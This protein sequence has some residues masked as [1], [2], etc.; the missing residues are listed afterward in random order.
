MHIRGFSKCKYQTLLFVCRFM[1]VVFKNGLF[2]I[3]MLMLSGPALGQVDSV[4]VNGD[5][6]PEVYK[7]NYRVEVP[8]TV[9]GI[10]VNL[11]NFYGMSK[12]PNSTEE[13]IQSLNK[14]NI[15]FFD[16][17]TVHVYSKSIDQASYIPFY[18]AIPLPL[19]C[20]VDQKMRKDFWKIEFLYIEALAVTGILNTTAVNLTNRYRPFTYEAA[21]PM[22][23]ATASNAKNS[24]FAG[25][26]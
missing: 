10:G 5:L 11:L 9:V 15:P 2:C 22:N 3:M 8:L 14:S 19:L 20:V 21:S 26:V 7:I 23:K 12:K 13:Q 25:H 18:I 1:T 4:K 17:W 24:F 6:K 16:R